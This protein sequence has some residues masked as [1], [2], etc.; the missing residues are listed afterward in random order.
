[1]SNN[2]VD[3]Y[4]GDPGTCIQFGRQTGRVTVIEDGE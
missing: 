3:V 1:M 4:M 2:V